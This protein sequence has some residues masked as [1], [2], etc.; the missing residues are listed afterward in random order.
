MSLI[1]RHRPQDFGVT[2]DA[3]GWTGVADLRAALAAR[4]V[5]LSHS[6][7]EALVST[8]DKQRFALSPD[9]S[10][11]RASQG[12]S[13]AVRLEYPPGDPP[14]LLFH[15]TVAR[16][17]PSIRASGLLPRQRQHVHLSASRELAAAVGRRRGIPIV[18]EVLAGRMHDAGHV[19]VLSPNGVWLTGG[20]PPEFLVLPG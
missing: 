8:N 3:E 6:E 5:D 16:F 10:R 2:L 15:G 4:G 12:H 18:L 19:F 9:G 17:L 20:V 11:I 14:E 13:V 1:L 7:L